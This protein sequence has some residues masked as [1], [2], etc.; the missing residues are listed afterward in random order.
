MSLSASPLSTIRAVVWHPVTLSIQTGSR[1]GA[2]TFDLNSLHGM[3]SH[4]L[5]QCKYDFVND[6]GYDHWPFM[7]VH[8]GVR[9]HTGSICL[10][11][12]GDYVKISNLSMTHMGLKRPQ[13]A[14]AI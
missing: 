10:Y 13:K 8:H 1:R 9:I 5:L 12:Q 3:P 14:E 6:E 4:L 7:S 11:F 2:I